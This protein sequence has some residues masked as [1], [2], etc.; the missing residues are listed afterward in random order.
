MRLRLIGLVLGAAVLAP[1]SAAAQDTSADAPLVR[2]RDG[3][4]SDLLFRVN[5]R[6]LQQVGRPIRTFRNGTG[7]SISPDGTRLAFA[8]GAHPRHP[9]ARRRTARIHFVNLTRWRSMG[10]ARVGRVSWL[11]LGWA[12][13]DRVVAVA[14]DGVGPQRLL[15]VDASTRKVLARRGYSGWAAYTLPIPGGLAVQVGPAEGV[16]PL[17]I[18]LL[19]ANGGV[20]TVTLD[21]IRTG[22]NY[23]DGGEVLTPAVTVD[24]DGG[25]LYAVAV[26]GTLVAE[27]ELA[28]GA[29]SYHSLGASAAKGNVDVWWR[30]AVW[31][32]DG[33]IALTGNHWPRP[34]AS[35]RA[36]CNVPRSSRSRLAAGFF[37]SKRPSDTNL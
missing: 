11:T 29:V 25:R 9:R 3:H 35:S 24:P 22:A 8:D 5:P 10:V 20:R 6:T 31:A 27:V 36:T 26:R 30:Q 4:G 15:W 1:P 21:G 32:G 37:G 7:L 34:L 18:L 19:D 13:W 33:R 12:S 17:R 28:T 16:G 14:D 23:D 2:M